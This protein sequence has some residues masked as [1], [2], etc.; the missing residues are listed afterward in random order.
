MKK[1]TILLFVCV[2][3]LS[4]CSCQNNQIQPEENQENDILIKVQEQVKHYPKYRPYPEEIKKVVNTT[5]DYMFYYSD[6]GKRYTFPNLDIFKSWYPETKIEDLEIHDIPKLYKTE[7]GGNVFLRPGTLLQ[8]PTVP[9]IYL[10]VTNGEIRPFKDTFIVE[11]I[12]GNNWKSNVV[13]LPN[14][15]FTHYTVTDSIN[16]IEEFPTYPIMTTID[17]NQNS[18]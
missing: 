6:N 14:Y 18:A 3:F 13:E 11:Q 1:I 5:T 15:Y 4:S 9:H 7:I 2:I 10:V 16:S 12:Y 17:K 8:T